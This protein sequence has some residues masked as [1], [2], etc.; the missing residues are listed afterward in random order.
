VGDGGGVVDIDDL[1]AY[2]SDGIHALQAD[3][4]NPSAHGSPGDQQTG[5][6]GGDQ[7]ECGQ[8]AF[9]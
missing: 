1:A 6:D 5:G 2:F 3:F 7:G 8:S 9:F 4:G